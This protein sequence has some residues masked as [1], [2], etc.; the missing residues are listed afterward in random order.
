MAQVFPRSTN[1]ISRVSIFGAV[2]F[3][4]GLLAVVYMIFRSP[5]VTRVAVVRDQ[6]V[7]FSHQHHVQGLGIDCRYCHTSVETSGFAGIPPTETCMSCHSQIWSESPMLEPVRASMRTNEPIR[8]NRVH[9]L[10]DYAYFN[11]AIHVQKGIGCSSCHGRVDLM[12]LTWKDQP[13]TMEWCLG[14]HREPEAQIRPREEVFNMSWTPPA[15]QLAM[16]K[17][18]L[19]KN[20][21]PVD[22]LTHCYTCHR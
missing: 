7:P 4:L 16:G 5:Y 18:A 14:C 17:D 1:V 11:H 21:I 9:E 8:W 2:F 13:L 22:R 3:A 15:N 6:P 20:H 12:P 10:P 19:V